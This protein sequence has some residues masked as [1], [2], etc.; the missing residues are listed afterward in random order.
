M[1]MFDLSKYGDFSHFLV[2][3][4]KIRDTEQG[5]RQLFNSIK[6]VFAFLCLMY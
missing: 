3:F 5:K 2:K 6:K 1:A 4:T